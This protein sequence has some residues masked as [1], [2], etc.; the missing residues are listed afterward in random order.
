LDWELSAFS[1][2]QYYEKMCI[3][4]I[5]E[6]KGELAKIGENINFLNG[7]EKECNSR[8]NVGS[9]EFYPGK[10]L[11]GLKEM[12]VENERERYKMKRND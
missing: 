3:E 9:F 7:G 12:Q 2:G 1:A 10:M 4:P 8:E 11:L 6:M 5:E